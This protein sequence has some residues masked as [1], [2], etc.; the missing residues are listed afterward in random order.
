MNLHYT[1]PIRLPIKLQNNVY[2]VII[3]NSDYIAFD[4]SRLYYLELSAL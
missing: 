1:Q 4:K 2:Y 3:P